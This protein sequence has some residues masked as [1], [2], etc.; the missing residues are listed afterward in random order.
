MTPENTTTDIAQLSPA[1]RALIV[2]SSTKTEIDLKA[3]AEEAA[4][5]VDIKDQV[6]RE[7]AHSVG[8][9][10]KKARTT[11]E[12]TGKA[13]RDDANAFA[14]SVIAEEKR[15]ISITE[16]EE[17]RV[18][19]LRDAFD[20]KMEAEKRAAEAKRAEIKA[21][22]DGIRALP[23]A[24]AGATSEEIAAEL[25]D[26]DQFKPSPEVFGD[27]V[28]D[29]MSAIADAVSSLKDLHARVLA[30]EA[31]AAAL[32]AARRQAE[33]ELAA[34]REAIAKERAELEALRAAAKPAIIANVATLTA[35]AY[36]LAD[37]PSSSAPVG[38]EI[39]PMV[40]TSFATDDDAPTAID[41]D[42]VYTPEPATPSNWR[43]RTFALHTADQ[44]D[45][46][47]AKVN[48]CGF[49]TFSGELR[50]VAS[51]IRDGQHDAALAAA[52]EKALIA[53]DNLL[54]DATVEAI[55]A[56][57]EKEQVAA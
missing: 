21:K 19:G 42:P 51:T 9:K 15:L 44:F 48:Q 34:E 11:I 18:I 38:A 17:K 50:Q 20:A 33:E 24:L 6:G 53:A 52:D 41:A 13:A 23:L 2:L 49:A 26:I 36:E 10:L 39:E 7:L 37:A 4:K 54:L 45:A 22:I 8:M 46:L 56:L 30:Q 5:I 31:A 35:A 55:D 3:M 40:V 57:I 14:K 32:D 47:A 27:Q 12:K 29:C 28:E 25:A 1:D 16:A 43:I